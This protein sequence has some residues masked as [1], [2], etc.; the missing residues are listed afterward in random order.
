M[1]HI[2]H[3]EIVFQLMQANQLFVKNE[4]VNFIVILYA[5]PLSSF[6]LSP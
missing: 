4:S 6:N 5:R 3:V 2:E 1:I